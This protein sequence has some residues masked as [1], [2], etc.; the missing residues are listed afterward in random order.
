LMHVGDKAKLTCP[1][2]LAYQDRGVGK[3]PP[4]AAI[5]FEVELI[6]IVK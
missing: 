4:G 1:A 3:I 2:E 5:T 6:S